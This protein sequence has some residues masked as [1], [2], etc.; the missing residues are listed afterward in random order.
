MPSPEERYLIWHQSFSKEI[1]FSKEVDLHKIAQ[2]Y[3]LSGGAIMNVI[4]Y[5]SL[6]T[7]EKNKNIIQLNDIVKGIMREYSKE[8]RTV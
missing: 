1:S 5:A 6:K 3:E 7:A 4:R 2:Q 8:G